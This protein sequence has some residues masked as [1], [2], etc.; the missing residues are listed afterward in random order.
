LGAFDWL[1]LAGFEKLLGVVPPSVA[2]LLLIG[3]FASDAV[4][5]MEPV[6]HSVSAS[7]QFI[8]YGTDVVTRGVICDFAEGIKRELLALLGQRDEWTAPIVI[9]AQHSRANLPEAPRL[10]VGFAQTGFGLKLQLDLV[11]ESGVSRPE[12]RREL[13]RVLV[14]EMIYRSHANIPAGTVYVSPPDWFLDGIP[15]QQADLTRDRVAAILALPVATGN[16]LSFQKFM[17]QRPD[18]LEGSGRN[19]YRAYAFAL[20]DLLVRSPDGPRHMTQFLLNLPASS[21]DPVVELGKHFPGLLDSDRVETTWQEQVAR[22]SADRPYWL[23]GSAETERQLGE[24]LRLRILDGKI[25]KRYELAQFPIFLKNKSAKKMLSSLARALGALATRAHPVYAPIIADYAGVAALLAR[26]KTLDIPR[27]LERLE[28][29][30]QA[31]AGQM[32]EIDDYLNWFE[33]TSLSRPSGE[34]ADYMKAAE[35]AAQPAQMK[36]DSISVYLNALEMQFDR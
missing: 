7:R 25:E 13:L 19:L 8:A 35:R 23:L 21:N 24:M 27:R 14:L 18:L 32:R 30:R 5:R 10:R 12:I 9:N 4:A 26:G 1:Q 15:A 31:I 6:E 11:I 2:C 33:A 36:R 34:F 29:T 28:K 22:I 20:V 17:E 16:V 3:L